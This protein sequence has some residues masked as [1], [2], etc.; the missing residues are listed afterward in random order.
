MSARAASRP[1]V[2]RRGLPWKLVDD[3][4]FDHATRTAA[5][6]TADR[7]MRGVVVSVEHARNGELWVRDRGQWSCERKANDPDWLRASGKAP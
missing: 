6:R 7:S 3:V 2:L 4:H 1:W 5:Q